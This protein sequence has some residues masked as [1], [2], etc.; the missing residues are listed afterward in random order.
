[1]KPIPILRHYLKPVW[2]RGPEVIQ[3]E[4]HNYCNENCIYCNNQNWDIPRGRMSLQVAEDIFKQIPST[5]ENMFFHLNGDPMLDTRLPQFTALSKRYFPSV[6]TTIYTNASIWENRDLLLDRNLDN[7]HMTISAATSETYTAV[8]GLTLF[9]DVVKI[10]EWF[11]TH[12]RP[13]QKQVIHFVIT[14]RNISELPRWKR[15]WKGYGQIVSPLHLGYEQQRSD[16]C[17]KGLDFKEIRQL[18]TWRGWMARNMPCHLWN[19]LSISWKGD[20]MGCVHQSY[21]FNFGQFGKISLLGAWYLKVHNKMQND[22]C[23]MCKCKA[24]GYR[25]ILD[26]WLP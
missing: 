23:E 14:N 12:K 3:M 8:H 21:D 10:A 19:N 6:P 25:R 1:M 13:D 22:S 11:H 5:L 26:K 16:D 24:K 9:D 18:G 17:I 7:V 4:T 15:Q 2:L 20:Y